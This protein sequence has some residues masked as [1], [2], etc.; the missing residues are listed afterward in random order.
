M[1]TNPEYKKKYIEGFVLTPDIIQETKSLPGSSVFPLIRDYLDTVI[2]WSSAANET[3]REAFALARNFVLPINPPR[4][5]IEKALR[6]IF[7]DHNVLVKKIRQALPPQ[8][9]DGKAQQKRRTRRRR[10]GT[11]KPAPTVI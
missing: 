9:R 1:K 10:P 2:D 3:Y 8:E 5:Q 11:D 7:R 6:H 4:I